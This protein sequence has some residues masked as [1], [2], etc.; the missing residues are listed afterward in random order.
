MDFQKK[1]QESSKMKINTMIA[2]VALVN[3]LTSVASA[4]DMVTD[5][6]RPIKVSIGTYNPLGGASRRAM[7]STLPMISLT[8][9]AGKTMQDKP[10]LF[11][12]FF[13]Y[14]QNRKQGT[15]VSVT[16]FGVSARYLSQSPR[17]QD[18]YFY[19]AGI[20]SYDV[21]IGTSNSK[22]GGKL[23]GGYERNDGYFGEVAYHMLSKING[24]DP[25]ALSFAIG[26]RF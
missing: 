23:F 2:I 25:S 9:E 5:T 10:V 16:A 19:G 26:R 14:A 3:A 4:Q 1:I 13:D 6:K 21:K 7:G 20:G 15:N 11:G 24:N 22:V 18:R 17:S 12:A 8:Y